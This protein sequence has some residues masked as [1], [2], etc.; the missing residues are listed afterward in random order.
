MINAAN[1][2]DKFLFT[3]NTGGFDFDIF[4]SGQLT[5]HEL[6][7]LNAGLM[8]STIQYND[9]G[10]TTSEKYF[11]NGDK[12][13][14][15]LNRYVRTNSQDVLDDVVQYTYDSNKRLLSESDNFSVTNYE[16]NGSEL[17]NINVFPLYTSTSVALPS[18][19]LFT[20]GGE[21]TIIDHTYTFDEKNRLTVDKAVIS[22]TSEEVTK[23]FTYE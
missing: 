10:D 3:Y 20:S 2:G 18:R 6:V 14:T 1:S 13:L 19:V 16:Y 8:D 23:S 4:A 5:I 11:Y 15:K 12:L 9:E 21:Q 22:G 7:F 17:N